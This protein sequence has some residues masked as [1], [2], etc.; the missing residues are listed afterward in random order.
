MK[1]GESSTP[2]RDQNIALQC[3]KLTETNYTTWA[4]MMETILKAYGLWET[5]EDTEKVDERKMHT[6]KAM[7]LT[8]LPEDILMQVAQYSKAKE[9]WESIKVRYIGADRVQKARLQTLRSELETLKM[10]TD[11]TVNDFAGKLGSIRGKCKSLGSNLKDKV[12]VGKL[13]NSVPKK[14][15]PIVASIEQYSEIDNMTFE[16]AVGRLTAYEE[17]LKS[18]DEPQEDYQ[19]KLLMASS[20]NQGRGRGRGRNFS[21][22][23][24][25]R[26]RGTSREQ[27]KKEMRCYECGEFGHFAY[28]CTKWKDKDKKQEA[29]LIYQSDEEPTLL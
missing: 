9:V 18:Q 22:E 27:S 15:L 25:G 14:F 24:R 10:K 20:S 1:I 8:T 23:E 29:H 12:L 4:I 13:L 26:G 16:E 7:I 28:E 5:L 17:R 3:P 2:T 21:K 6:T 19:S 11:E